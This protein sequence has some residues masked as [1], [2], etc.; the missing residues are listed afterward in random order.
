LTSVFK[1]AAVDCY[2]LS[3]EVNKVKRSKLLKA[4]ASPEEAMAIQS[5]AHTAGL[6]IAAYLRSCGLGHTITPPIPQTVKQ[7]LAKWSQNLNQLSYQANVGNCIDPAAVNA[8]RD[9]AK[10]LL[11]AIQ[12]TVKEAHI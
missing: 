3:K 4:T 7:D 6:S 5:K 9:E 2:P 12:Q 10:Q 11:R 8:L 1:F